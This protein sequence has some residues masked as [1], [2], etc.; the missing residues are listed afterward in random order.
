MLPGRV[1]SFLGEPEQCKGGCAAV[2]LSVDTGRLSV[3]RVRGR[4]GVSIMLSVK[5]W[6]SEVKE[7]GAGVGSVPPLRF[8]AF[9]GPL[10]HCFAQSL[11][12]FAADDK[13]VLGRALTSGL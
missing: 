1:Q 10:S 12:G 11:L 5:E 7:G 4:R 9:V 13:S 3:V 2:L 6:L 8:P